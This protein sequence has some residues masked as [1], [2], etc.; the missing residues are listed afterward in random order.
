MRT[1]TVKGVGTAST[2]PDYAV[3]NI[4]LESGDFEY[5]KALE[6]AAKAVDS[7]TSALVSVGFEKSDLKTSDYSVRTE[8]KSVRDENGNYSQE[9]DGYACR[10]TLKLGLDFNTERLGK[11]LSALTSVDPKP[12]VSIDFTVKDP[13]AVSEKLLRSAAENARA[14]AQILCDASGVK[15]GGLVSIDYDWHDIN[16][17]SE[18]RADS[19]MMLAKNSAFADIEPEEISSSDSARFVWEIV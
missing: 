10:Y 14:K 7:M 11:A 13:S 5:D 3:I 4:T 6:T 18:C 9:F 19:P 1:I 2:R 8:Y 17:V 15:L 12:E 16:I